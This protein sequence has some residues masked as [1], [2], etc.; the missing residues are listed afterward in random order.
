MCLGMYVCLCECMS[1]M[2]RHKSILDLLELKLQAIVNWSAWGLDLNAGPLE[3]Q[4]M[5][6]ATEPCL[7]CPSM[8]I[9]VRRPYNMATVERLL[10]QINTVRAPV[11]DNMFDLS[12]LSSVKNLTLKQSSQFLKG[13]STII[14]FYWSSTKPSTTNWVFPI[15]QMHLSTAV[16]MLWK[17]VN[18]VALKV[19]K[20]LRRPGQ[21]SPGHNHTLLGFCVG[22]ED[23]SESS[24]ALW[25]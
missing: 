25:D 19:T 13:N 7:L 12:K 15:T 3:E 1:H 22:W 4:E 5:F 14:H 11:R 9:S 16:H 8:Y 20:E 10:L 23:T 17:S 24:A 2:W 6:S 18:M 21:H